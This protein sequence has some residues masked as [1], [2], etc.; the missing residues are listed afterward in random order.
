VAG[1]GAWRRSHRCGGANSA[2]PPPPALTPARL[3]SDIVPHPATAAALPL[4]PPLPPPPPR[5]RSFGVPRGMRGLY[6]AAAGGIAGSSVSFLL[7]P[8]DTLKTMSQADLP[9][10]LVLI[11]HAASL[12]P[13]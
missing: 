6:A 9:P 4:T 12:T 13:Y 11:G 8:L 3:S 5:R 7:H 2:P 10:P 1:C